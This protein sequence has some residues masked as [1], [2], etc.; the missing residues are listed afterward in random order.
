MK[1]HVV[2]AFVY[3]VA[4]MACGVFYREFTKFSDF[5]GV[6]TLGKVHTHLFMLGMVVFL[7]V[8]LFD[9]KLSLRQSKL[10][11]PFVIVY[12]IGVPLASVMMLVRGVLQ[13]AGVTVSAGADGAVAGISGVGHVVTAAGIVLFFVMLLGALKEKKAERSDA[14]AAEN[15]EETG[16]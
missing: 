15:G 6:T 7:L 5:T 16:E 12:N 8:A 14:G 9:A 2:I 3:A 4:A 11:K 10:Y 13:V 1:R